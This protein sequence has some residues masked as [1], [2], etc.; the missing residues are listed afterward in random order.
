M[1]LDE[2]MHDNPKYQTE[3]NDQPTEITLVKEWESNQD[4]LM[5]QE[6]NNNYFNQIMAKNQNI[7]IL[8]SSTMYLCPKKL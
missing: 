5:L 4:F 6:I 8:T 7:S 3:Q 2:I 1:N